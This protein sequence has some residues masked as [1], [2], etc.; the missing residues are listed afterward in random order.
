MPRVPTTATRH[1]TGGDFPARSPTV[2][3]ERNGDQHDQIADSR[4]NLSQQMDFNAAWGDDDD[5]A[6]GHSDEVT[7]Q[8]APDSG[9]PPSEQGGGGN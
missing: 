9:E 1:R 3:A 7:A 8:H 6:A 5:G 4:S 2:A